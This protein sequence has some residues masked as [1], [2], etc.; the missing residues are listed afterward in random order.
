MSFVVN[1]LGFSLLGEL[2]SMRLGELL[3]EL[4]NDE[5]KAP[6]DGGFFRG[7]RPFKLPAPFDDPPPR[8]GNGP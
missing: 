3:G 1:L 4:D 6:I 5:P 7:G 8:G 2:L